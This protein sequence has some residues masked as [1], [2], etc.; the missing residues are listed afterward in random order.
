MQFTEQSQQDFGLIM[1]SDS[2]RVVDYH[3]HSQFSFDGRSSIDQMC[4]RAVEVGITDIGFC[5][6]VEFDPR[7]AAFGFLD[8]EKYSEAIDEARSSYGNRLRIRKGLEVGY[9]EKRERDVRDWLDVRKTDFLIGSIH[10]VNNIA[11]DSPQGW[12]SMQSS[13]LT[14]RYYSEVGKTVESGLFDIVGHFDLVREYVAPNQYKP[15]EVSQLIDQIFGLMVS[16]GTYLEINSRR[17]V[18]DTVP[19]SDLIQR[20]L[21]L[22]GKRFSFGSDAHSND[23]LGV[24]IVE[25][26]SLVKNLKPKAFQLVFE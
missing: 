12:A 8:Y 17:R 7:D 19:S 2:P 15:S 20:Y 21:S 25:A 26:M 13:T 14:H 22:G 4:R 18:H 16:N 11:N 6:H 1:V 23:D 5:E 24:G 10:Y 9:D 3:V